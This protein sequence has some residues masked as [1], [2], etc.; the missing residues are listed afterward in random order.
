[1]AVKRP[2]ELTP[3]PLDEEA[4]E[5]PEAK[6]AEAD[7]R[8]ELVTREGE[9]HK[10]FSHE[11]GTVAIDET[12]LEEFRKRNEA[13]S[14][15]RSARARE[16][17]RREEEKLREV[18]QRNSPAGQ[19]EERLEP[20]IKASRFLLVAF[21]VYFA[22]RALVGLGG[23]ALGHAAPELF[24][25]LAMA[26]LAAFVFLLPNIPL[27][28]GKILARFG[29]AVTLL[30]FGV[31]G[32]VNLVGLYRHGPGARY[33]WHGFQNHLVSLAA[34]L[35]ILVTAAI[36]L[37]AAWRFRAALLEAFENPQAP[38]FGWLPSLENRDTLRTLLYATEALMFEALVILAV[39]LLFRGNPM[40]LAVELFS[41]P[42]FWL[43]LLYPFLGYFYFRTIFLPKL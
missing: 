9:A 24:T 16:H 10:E 13:E 21:A 35:A 27:R 15:E 11:T 4:P 43:F 41:N 40:T 14:A 20:G 1:M 17:Y 34:S 29:Y 25:Y 19:L 32:I 18:F 26:A 31:G 38:V 5:T 12:G 8:L 37:R 36:V 3:T 22:A 39:M 30:Y 33:E 23:L 6:Y 2:L 28:L 7:R 42:T